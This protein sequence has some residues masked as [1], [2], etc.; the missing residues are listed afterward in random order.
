M[1]FTK[2]VI[3]KKFNLNIFLDKLRKFSGKDNTEN[4]EQDY[5]YIILII[6]HS[7][8]LR[9]VWAKGDNIFEVVVVFFFFFFLCVCSNVGKIILTLH[10]RCHVFQQFYIKVQ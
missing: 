9:N 8:Y 10:R 5:V 3:W 6:V 7:G 2:K 4:K 1:K